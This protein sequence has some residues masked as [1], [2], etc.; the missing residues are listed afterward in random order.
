MNSLTCTYPV[1]KV[2]HDIRR[3]STVRLIA[4]VVLV[5]ALFTWDVEAQSSGVERDRNALVALY[6]ATDGANWVNN[7]NWLTDESLG[8]WYGVNTDTA[9]RVVSI[10]LKGLPATF[11]RGQTSH[12]LSG[13]LPSEL[14][15]LEYLT[16]L[17]LGINNI[18][19]SIPKEIGNLTRL[20]QLNLEDNSMT[21]ELPLELGNLTSLSSLRLGNNQLSGPIPI[22][23]NNLSRLTALDLSR[24][25]ISG[26]IPIELGEL[27][28]L[29]ILLLDGNFLIGELPV[30]IEH[31]KNLQRF[32]LDSNNLSG[33]L[34]DEIGKL[35][36]LRYLT[37]FD[38]NFSGEIPATIGNL[39]NLTELDLA[40]NFL[41]G[42]LPDEIGKLT[43]LEF[44]D[45]SR[46][47]LTGRI[48]PQLIK[49][50]NLTYLNLSDNDLV[51]PV[52]SGLRNLPNLR[53]LYLGNNNLSGPVP[54]R[55]VDAPNILIFSIAGNRVCVPGTHS[56]IFWLDS[57]IINDIF[58]LTFCNASDRSILERLFEDTNG[59]DWHEAQGW[60][61]DEVA[62]ERWYGIETDALGR[63][64]SLDLGGN[65]LEG[66]L[67]LDL[68]YLTQ[69]RSLILEDNS[70]E[71]RLPL[72]LRRLELRSFQFSNT[73]LCVPLEL[74]F[75]TWLDEAV[76]S[77]GSGL[78]CDSLTEREVVTMFFEET[79]GNSWTE[80]ENWLSSESLDQWHGVVVDDDGRV[81]SLDLAS[82][83]LAGSVPLELSRLTR[84]R[85]LNF[86]S[87]ALSGSI[88][89][90]LGDLSDLTSLNLSV[91]SLQ[92]EIPVELANLENLSDL[93]LSYNR[94]TG[95]IPSE[96]GNLR[97]LNS[98]SLAGNE[99][100]G[101]IPP[102]LGNL[103][104]LKALLLGFNRL[105][106]G[107]PTEIGNLQE[108]VTLQLQVNALSGAIPTEIGNLAN[109]ESLWLYFNDFTGE[110]PPQIGSLSN[111][112]SIDL[113]FNRLSGNI[114]RELGNFVKLE[115]L[116]LG[117]NRFE[118]QIPSELGNLSQ[119]RTLSLFNNRLTGEIPSG[120]GN[121]S[122]LT[123]LNVQINELSGSIPSE[124]GGLTRL[125]YLAASANDLVGQLPESFG[126]L[127]ELEILYLHDND[128]TGSIPSEFGGLTQ[129]RYLT[130]SANRGLTGPIPIE[131][132]ALKQI[133]V[134]LTVDT[135]ICLPL[136]SKFS[137]WLVRVYK[138][139]IRSC[140]SDLPLLALLTQATQSHDFPVPL[141]AGERA[142]LRVF[143][144]DTDT[145]DQTIPE[146]SARFYLD[147]QEV[148]RA[149]MPSKELS[150][151]MRPNQG[152]LE[153]TSNIEIPGSVIQSGLEL[154]IEVDSEAATDSSTGSTAQSSAST[155]IPVEVHELP[156]FE[157]T[158]IPFVYRN[159]NDQSIVNLVNAMAANPLEH[160]MFEETRT[161]LPVADLNVSAHEPVISS[162]DD[163]V[164][165]LMQTAIIRAV[166]GG[167]GH[168]LGMASN[169]SGPI[170]G[171]AYISGQD[172]FSL[173]ESDTIAHELG[174]N[175][176]L[177]HAPCGVPSDTDSS[178][179]YPDG[180]AGAWGYDFS[181]GG[182]LVQ[183][184]RPDLM[185]YCRPRWISD[186]HFTN[187]LRYRLFRE[188]E[189][190]GTVSAAKNSLLV[191]GKRTSEDDL[192]MNPSFL[193]HAPPL[194][195]D[196]PGEYEISGRTAN[197]GEL[198][199][200]SFDMQEVAD[201]NGD[202][203]FVFVIPIQR[204][205]E[206]ELGAVVLKGSDGVTADDVGSDMAISL[207]RN[208]ISRQIRGIISTPR[209]RSTTRSRTIEE[210]NARGFEVL[211]NRGSPEAGVWHP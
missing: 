118:G 92:G 93:N 174:H 153:S 84:L 152:S 24:N 44:L 156:D 17:V 198:F 9:G 199:A 32:T 182:N 203:S 131:L 4:L 1:S 87:N 66:T 209:A 113:E 52:I 170:L 67:P 40:W 2:S 128:L 78:T 144:L 181:N 186:Y 82:N 125:S 61:D 34:P 111:L 51:G 117:A 183:P 64:V 81:T 96:F 210:A 90:E 19:G 169:V 97:N 151:P 73:Q 207:L 100:V 79:K 197:G 59:S 39:N 57:V 178:Y 161:L 43:D 18:Y 139:R 69:L 65:G 163:P 177:L 48:N 38:N 103:E 7:T 176:S 16:T 14:G 191:W 211:V 145:A 91:N 109:L 160:E 107:I 6:E 27:T 204:D 165:L 29:T 134:F 99:L 200:M 150:S 193:V 23:I 98:L 127:A 85:S 25:R 105:H 3:V 31:L 119:L 180:T 136:D 5:H 101:V 129:L 137:D 80:T 184:S 114:P 123:H 35:E 70:L 71:G 106:G 154:E 159:S 148:Y 75:Q 11:G 13:E 206:S 104:D 189:E 120:L 135:S 46:N 116:Y 42:S 47:E 138:R 86:E 68:G 108:L 60:A 132:I 143:P 195:P 208:P 122:D 115:E 28:R 26:Q 22:S 202:S 102:E 30:E 158:L 77:A 8:D 171:I 21:G 146:V 37:A 201:S 62:L 94:L 54:T 121:L 55:F 185:S 166:E 175:L 45:V 194:L 15:D 110:V 95:S 141:V 155:R 88:P 112:H 72:S 168:Y 192:V 187:A 53:F 188:F 167:T 89:P 124:L 133:E 173:P 36:N 179:P 33:P 142:L 172:S 58:S 76:E 162:S 56:F 205:W 196:A 50:T 10:Y 164:D 126:S 157:L 147:D 74:D 41:T 63:V 83:N 140:A 49:L 190:K 20:T 130:L 12:G 149:N